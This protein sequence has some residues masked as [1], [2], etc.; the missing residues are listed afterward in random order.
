MAAVFTHHVSLAQLGLIA[1]SIPKIAIITG[2]LDEL[3]DPRCSK[4]LHEQLPVSLFYAAS[5]G[6]IGIRGASIR[7]SRARAMRCRV[8]L[9]SS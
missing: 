5:A 8:R 7:S 6:L 4:D 1:T 3:V 2:D 9:L